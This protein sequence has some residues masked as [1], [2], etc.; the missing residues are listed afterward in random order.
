MKDI[1]VELEQ[2]K[3]VLKE[4]ERKIASPTDINLV[5]YVFIPLV[6]DVNYEYKD[7]TLSL[8]KNGASIKI[9]ILDYDKHITTIKEN[10]NRIII[11][12][13]L[14]LTGYAI[15]ENSLGL[16]HT[17]DPNDHVMGILVNGEIEQP[18]Q[19]L[20][21]LE[22]IYPKTNVFDKLHFMWRSKVDLYN[23]IKITLLIDF[24]LITGSKFIENTNYHFLESYKDSEIEEFKKKIKGIADLYGIRDDKAINN[25]AKKLSDIIDYYSIQI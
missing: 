8:S 10:N 22:I 4:I 13:I 12:N 25:L 9:K 18:G 21:K 6:N 1:F 19:N 15:N 17:L 20:S 24:D 7:Q 16:V 23:N 3:S 2:L 5:E 11:N 14:L